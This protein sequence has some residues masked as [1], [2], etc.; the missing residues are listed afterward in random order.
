M[1]LLTA[2]CR[3]L[4]NVYNLTFEACLHTFLRVFSK[5]MYGKV[6]VLTRQVSSGPSS[7]RTLVALGYRQWLSQFIVSVSCCW[8]GLHRRLVTR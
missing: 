7:T 8:L 3:A 1:H 6:H 5:N 2:H 4:Y